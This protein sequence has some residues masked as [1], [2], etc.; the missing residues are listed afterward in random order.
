[1][2]LLTTFFLFTAISLGLFAQNIATFE[3]FDLAVDTFL[4]DAG[5]DG[6]FGADGIFL[7]NDYNAGFDAWSGWAISTKTDSLTAGFLNQYS[8]IS[9]AGAVGS[10]TYALSFSFGENIMRLQD[11]TAE[12]EGLYI[13]NSTYAYYSMLEGD[14]FAKR[15]GGET[16]DDPDFF[17]LTIRKYLN[18]EQGTDSVNVYLADY[19]FED[20]AEDYIINAW[21]YVDLTSLGK[22][23]SLGFSLSSSDVGQFGMN[24][25]A[26]FCIDHVRTN[27]VI[28]ALDGWDQTISLNVFPNPVSSQ[29]Y[30]DWKGGTSARLEVISLKGQLLIKQPMQA[31]RNLLDVQKLPKGIYVLKAFEGTSWK[32]VRFVKY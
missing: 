3:D 19:R 4:N 21:T 17:L 12:V 5:P 27:A 6:G 9:G 32:A 2:K 24:T 16:G 25:P 20:N 18:G 14:A 8:V 1:M 30:I 11:S 28:T 23:D 29:L 31:G 26:Y 13:N 22:A 10:E 15:F 7:P